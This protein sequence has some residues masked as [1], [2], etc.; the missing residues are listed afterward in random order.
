MQRGTCCHLPRKSNSTDTFTQGSTWV[1]QTYI[2]PFFSQNETE[3]DASLVAAQANLL[4]FVQSSLNKVWERALGAAGAQG[5][6]GQA[7][8]GPSTP[9]QS[10]KADPL[11]FAK[12]L[13]NTY[14]PTVVGAMQSQSNG[15]ASGASV[16]TPAQEAQ[17]RLSPQPQTS[18]SPSFP[19]PEVY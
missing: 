15:S 7:S 3:I 8:S 17:R 1:F 11:A 10:H 5:A 6:T 12:G 13:W 9:D 19:E 2:H 18:P 4:A 14:G 16:H